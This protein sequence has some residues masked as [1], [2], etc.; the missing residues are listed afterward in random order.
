MER[1]RRQLLPRHVGGERGDLPR[2]LAVCRRGR[3][4]LRAERVAR[5]GAVGRLRRLRDGLPERGGR[6]LLRERRLPLPRRPLA[7]RGWKKAGVPSAPLPPARAPSYAAR[8]AA[9]TQHA[10]TISLTLVVAL[11]LGVPAVALAAALVAVVVLAARQRQASGR[12]DAALLKED[13]LALATRV[14]EANRALGLRA[15]AAGL[16]FRHELRE[17]GRWLAGHMGGAVEYAQAGDEAGV[18]TY[19]PYVE[20][21]QE[22]CA[23]SNETFCLAADIASVPSNLTHDKNIVG[24]LCGY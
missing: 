23:A 11:V 10:A 19:T 13:A 15:A 5:R 21:V 4:R 2:A 3:R 7:V 9:R 18:C 1:R 8:L 6:R 24:C 17:N 12:V 14:V 16:W 20:P 22:V